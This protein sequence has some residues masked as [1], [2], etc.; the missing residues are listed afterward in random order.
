MAGEA[1]R[2]RI[3]GTNVY[4]LKQF[5]AQKL[6]TKYRETYPHITDA[7]VF[8]DIEGTDFLNHHARMVRATAKINA[9]KRFIDGV[10]DE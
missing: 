1:E 7:F 5:R 9:R 8:E 4:D 6:M 2:A 10:F 3:T